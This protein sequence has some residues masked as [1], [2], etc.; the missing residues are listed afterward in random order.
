M[1]MGNMLEMVDGSFT[2]SVLVG[3]FIFQTP[4]N[5]VMTG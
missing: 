2:P 1:A 3:I 5:M 4:D